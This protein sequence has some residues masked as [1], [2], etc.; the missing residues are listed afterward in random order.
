MA[1]NTNHTP[2]ATSLTSNWIIMLLTAALISG[3]SATNKFFDFFKRK[4]VEVVKPAQPQPLPVYYSSIPIKK[5]SK[6]QILFAQTALTE[7]GYKL[8]GIDGVWG[9]KSARAMRRFEISVPIITADGFLS[10]LNLHH[11]SELTNIIPSDIKVPK[12]KTA[13]ATSQPGQRAGILAKLDPQ[14]PLSEGAQLIIVDKRY[15]VY[16]KPNPYSAKLGAI[17]PGSGVYIIALQEGF[18]QIES[19]N[20]VLGYVVA[21]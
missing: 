14:S 6:R 18:Y 1:T 7:L 13:R 3:C 5:P 21:D 8:G 17:E 19:M 16:T 11:L 9:P 10:A 4:P 20:R 12:K 2:R 15:D